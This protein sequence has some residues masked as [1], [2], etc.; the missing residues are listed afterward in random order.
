M[1]WSNVAQWATI[2][3]CTAPICGTLLWHLNDLF[4]RPLLIPRLEIERLAEKMMHRNPIDPEEAAF[5]EE[6]AAWYRSETYEQGKWRRVRKALR[7]K[8]SVS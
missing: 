6:D 5:I 7:R 3:I 2:G 4:I 1:D 8:A